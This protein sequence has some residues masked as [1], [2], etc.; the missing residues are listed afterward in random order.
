[1]DEPISAPLMSASH[2]TSTLFRRTEAQ[3]VDRQAETE[4]PLPG[5]H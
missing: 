5:L 3:G 2:R 4:T 1:M